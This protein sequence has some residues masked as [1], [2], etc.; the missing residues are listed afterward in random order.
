[1]AMRKYNNPPVLSRKKAPRRSLA[2]NARKLAS[3]SKT[4]AR[5]PNKAFAPKPA[6][7]L[8]L[9]DYLRFVLKHSGH[10]P[11]PR[12]AE[13]CRKL[14]RACGHKTEAAQL[15]EVS[16]QLLQLERLCRA[17]KLRIYKRFITKSQ[18]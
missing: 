12:Q 7:K 15:R 5:E 9:R 6:K 1:M 18:I 13:L 8:S 17:L 4:P 14:A 10:H 2:R 16:K 3:P 11:L